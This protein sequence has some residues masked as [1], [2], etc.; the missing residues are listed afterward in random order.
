MKFGHNFSIRRSDF[1]KHVTKRITLIDTL[2]NKIFENNNVNTLEGFEID[3]RKAATK[4]VKRKQKSYINKLMKG[5][6]SV[7]LSLRNS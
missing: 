6:E 1:R 7:K 2:N 5:F 3:D 4:S